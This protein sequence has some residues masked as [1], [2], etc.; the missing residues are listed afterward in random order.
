I[1]LKIRNARNISDEFEIFISGS[2]PYRDKVVIP[3]K[4]IFL[5]SN[6]TKIINVR[7]QIPKN[8]PPGDFDIIFS[9]SSK[10]NLDI[11]SSDK[12]KIRIIPSK[13][14]SYTHD[15]PDIEA[16]NIVNPSKIGINYYGNLRL[17]DRGYIIN[18]YEDCCIGSKMKLESLSLSGEWFSKGGPRDSP[19]IEWVENLE[20][21]KRKIDEGVFT[22]TVYDALVCDWRAVAEKET[23]PEKCEVRGTMICSSSC[24]IRSSPSFD[25]IE[26]TKEII[27]K[28]EGENSIE[29][30]CPVNCIF[31]IDRRNVTSKY[32]NKPLSNV[33][34]YSEIKGNLKDIKQKLVVNGKKGEIGPD[35][36]ITSSK[37]SKENLKEGEKFYIKIKLKN[38]GDKEAKIDVISTNIKNYEFIYYPKNIKAG[39]E[40]E[41]LV[42]ARAGD[43]DNIN[44]EFN[45]RAD[46]IGCLPTLNFREKFN[47]GNIKLVGKL[48][49]CASNFDC[50][51]QEVCCEGYCMDTSTG[52]CDDLD[53]D[54]IPETW[55][56]YI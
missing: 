40:S 15:Q 32:S 1:G 45:Y 43:I 53:G 34:G 12:L 50:S 6:E 29:Y 7:V 35:L 11:W 37:I 49:K 2:Y 22:T 48:K 28:N 24:S 25:F 56:D 27:L 52:F 17:I 33:Y 44:F 19:P 54:G 10:K 42:K 26:A 20:E 41:L 8:T 21:I 55:M 16:L 36:E 46:S 3:E 18:N 23:G 47:I 51:S 5:N 13:V 9:V 4:T 14:Q 38:V 39:E 30:E 31:F